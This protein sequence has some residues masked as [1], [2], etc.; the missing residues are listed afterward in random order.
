MI[1]SFPHLPILLK[2]IYLPPG[3]KTPTFVPFCRRKK[4]R[5]ANC[6]PHHDSVNQAYS[7]AQVATLVNTSQQVSDK[8]KHE[9]DTTQN[10]LIRVNTSPHVTWY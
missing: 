10:Q 5:K 8:G 1:R 7:N 3:D 6:F 4:V 9:P 2:N